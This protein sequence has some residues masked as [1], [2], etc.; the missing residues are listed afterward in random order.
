M[1]GEICDNMYWCI[2]STITKL[3]L[4]SSAG[5]D[6]DLVKVVISQCQKKFV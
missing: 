3:Y 5:V 6:T 4:F 1:K 2:F